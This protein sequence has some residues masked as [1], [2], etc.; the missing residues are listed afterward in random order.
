MLCREIIVVCSQI[1]TKHTNTL[2]WQN[3]RLLNVKPGGHTLN[4]GLSIVRVADHFDPEYVGIAPLRNVGMYQF[5][6]RDPKDVYPVSVGLRQ[7]MKILERIFKEP[8]N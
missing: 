8:K 6:R 1:H 5:T 3:V 4:T 2:C 7:D